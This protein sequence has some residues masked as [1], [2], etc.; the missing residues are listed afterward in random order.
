[1]GPLSRLNHYFWTYKWLFI[2]GLL[3]TMASAGFQISVPS[4]VRQ[5]IDSIPR[6]V[7]VHGVFEGTAGQPMIYSYLFG[8][9]LLFAITIIGLSVISGLFM[10]LMRQTVVV[11][12]RHIEYDLRNSL[13]R[14]LQKLSPRFYQEY[15]TGDVITRATDDIEKVRRYIGP[16]IMY[17]TRSLVM[18]LTAISVMFIISPKLTLYALIPMPLL[19]VSVFFMARMVH[20]RSDRLQEQY[21]TV[22]SR[23]QEALAGIRV[24]KAYTRE[25]AESE[26]FSSESEEYKRRNLDLALVE[27]AWRPVFLLMVGIS[28]IIVVWMGGRLVAQGTITIGNIVEY[29]LYVSMM[30]WPVASLGFVI[31]MIQRASASVSRLHKIMD[32][33]PDI[34]DGMQTDESIQE[35]DGR[36]TFRDVSFSYEAEQEPAL[37]NVSFDLKPDETLAIVGRTGAGKSTLVEMIPRLLE[38]TEGQVEVD[39]HDVRSIPLETLRTNIGY[40]PQDVFLFSDTVANNIAFGKLDADGDEIERAASEADLLANVDDFPNG[41]DTFVGERGITLSGGQKQR[42]SIAR[43]LIRDPRILIFDDALSA[44]D[45]ATERNILRSLRDRQG[46]HTLIIVSHRLSAV[47]EADLI[48]VMDEGRIAERGTHDELMEQDGVY[49]D[50]YRKQ[51]LEEEIEAYG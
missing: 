3:C 36:I 8:T 34:A 38:P 21:S 41:F 12:S 4:V 29:V 22:T 37:K 45:T 32:A 49:A 25:D 26:A 1:M 10:F 16:A 28:T 17:V 9:L 40:V 48:L 27:S 24:L 39:G 44:V 33:D 47:Q 35:I 23:V 11:A 43:A 2:P 5:T 20:W 31:T 30:T 7:Q 15:S 6:F 42:T 50:L 13:Y 14:H 19:A 51:L 46:S 18:V